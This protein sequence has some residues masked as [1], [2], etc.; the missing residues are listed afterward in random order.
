MVYVNPFA[1]KDFLIPEVF[2]AGFL[3]GSLGLL[4]ALK[5]YEESADIPN[6]KTE[7]PCKQCR[8]G[9]KLIGGVFLLSSFLTL[10][11]NNRHRGLLPS[12][13]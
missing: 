9:P 2:S 6:D 13:Y 4:C 12:L 10:V 3:E 5:N 7:F 8:L 1:R 11:P